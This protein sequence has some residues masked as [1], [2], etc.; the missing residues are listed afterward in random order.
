MN[1][2]E[3]PQPDDWREALEAFRA[4]IIS[5]EKLGDEID[6][7]GERLDDEIAKL[8]LA[9]HSPPEGWHNY[10]L[11]EMYDKVIE[12][13]SYRERSVVMVMPSIKPVRPE[14]AFSWMSV[15][16]PAN[17]RVFRISVRNAD[18]DDAYNLA[19]RDVLDDPNL[20]KFAF[21]A[22][23]EA[24]NI[25]PADGLLQLFVDIEEAQVDGISGIYH[26]KGPGGVPQCWGNPADVPR[27]WRPFMPKPDAVTLCNGIGMGFSVYR[28]DLFRRVSFPWFKT[29]QRYT[30]NLAH[31]TIRTQD[32][33]FCD[34]AAREVG[35]KFAVSTRVKVGHIDDDGVVW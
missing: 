11:E 2:D 14:V 34:K 12:A 30:N 8:K 27:N 24:D 20:S 18:V 5:F 19:V 7:I 33:Y 21:L 6:K 22:T 28:M 23:F 16:T 35:A 13:D 26:T 1:T 31:E 15:M 4:K 25:V 17:H 9:V 3:S 10:R 29:E 32:M